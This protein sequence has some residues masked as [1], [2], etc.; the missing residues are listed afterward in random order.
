MQ[1]KKNRLRPSRI[2]V[3]ASL[4]VLVPLASSTES[5]QSSLDEGFESTPTGSLPSSWTR[6]GNSQ[7]WVVDHTAREGNQSLF[8][9]GSPGGC[10]SALVHRYVAIPP[11]ATVTIR[12]A[13]NA[14]TE[15]VAGCHGESNSG[16]SL[17]QNASWTT[18]SRSLFG[19]KTNGSAWGLEGWVGSVQVGQWN[20]VELV[21]QRSNEKVEVHYR[22]NGEDLGSMGSS[23]YSYEASLT[24]LTFLSYDWTT[25]VDEVTVHAGSIPGAPVNLT[26]SPTGVLGQIRLQWQSPPGN[27]PIDAYQIY[28]LDS[29][30]NWTF[31]G[32]T[33]VTSAEVPGDALSNHRF[34]VTAVNQLG[35]SEP[36]E[37]ACTAASP[38]YVGQ[39]PLQEPCS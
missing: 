26:A 4:L 9:K 15:G 27:N 29:E 39:P 19:T 22:V 16:I 24:H 31:E 11:K 12:A 6:S 21:Y 10:W 17:Y 2:A 1:I 25:Y 3:L 28:R 7:S 37:T 38:W 20:D 35:E 13:I 36:S 8:M 32:S 5:D 34:H 18:P 14:T 33:N 23:P 30:D